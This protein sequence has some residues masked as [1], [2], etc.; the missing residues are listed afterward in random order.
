MCV[1]FGSTSF[2]AKVLVSFVAEK[3]GF[4]FAKWNLFRSDRSDDLADVPHEHVG[5]NKKRIGGKRVAVTA[6]PHLRNW[7]DV[8]IS[9]RL[10]LRIKRKS[11]DYSI[12]SSSGAVC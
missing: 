3:R 10:Y 6:I 5:V 11:L 7:L 12:P 4:G 8:R 1:S 2:L 9:G